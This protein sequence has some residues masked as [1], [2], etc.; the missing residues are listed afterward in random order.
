MRGK[1]I[2]VTHKDYIMPEN[3]IYLPI[4]VGEGIDSLN[5][6]FQADNIGEN[7]SQKNSVY[8]ELTAIYWA[9]KN[10]TDQQYIGVSH[11]RRHFS[12]D[13]KRHSCISYVISEEK[14]LSILEKNKII[15]PEKKRYY[16]LSIKKHYFISGKDKKAK[17]AKED[18]SNLEKAILELSPEYHN[19]YLHVMKSTSAH[20]LNMFIM[21][22]A[23]F[24][25]YCSWLFPIIDNVVAANKDKERTRFAGALSE[26][27]LDIWLRHNKRAVYETPLIELEKVKTIYKIKNAI[28]RIVNRKA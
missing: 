28:L 24:D 10:L 26:F 4:C 21:K 25:S 13:R 17:T 18:I 16:F 7:I 20:L 5:V 22:R 6:K 14:I 3:L 11:Y 12:N 23:D 2:V 27:C 19:D 9:W 15:V 8:C 1:I